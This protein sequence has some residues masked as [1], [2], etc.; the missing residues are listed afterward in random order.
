MAIYA[1][2]SD[3]ELCQAICMGNRTAFDQFFRRYYP[4]LCAYASRFVSLHDAE[5]VVQDVMLWLWEERGRLERIAS[6]D[7]YLF[8]AVRNRCLT[9]LDSS[10]VRKRS[11]ETPGEQGHMWDDPDFYVAREL[12]AQIE[13][14]LAALPE[15]YREAFEMHRFQGLTYREIASRLAVSE[16]TVD[17]R[18]SQALRLLRISLADFLPAT[19]LIM[20]LLEP[21]S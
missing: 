3:S 8:R 10:A 11:D 6:P 7:R 4:S 5:E 18:I 15:S 2:S 19:A 21:R 16:K 13:S 12:A 14:A 20:M 9:L 17:Y 1:E